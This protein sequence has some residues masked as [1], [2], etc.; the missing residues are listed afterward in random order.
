MN[1]TLHLLI[2]KIERQLSRLAGLILVT[3][4]L[5]MSGY[6]VQAQNCTVNAGIDDSVC[7]TYPLQLHGNSGGVYQG[8]GNIHW[9]QKSGPTVTISNPYALNPYISGYVA[10]SVYWFYI[11]AKCLDGSLVFDSVMVRIKPVTVAD[12]GPDLLSCPGTNVLTLA[13]NVPG[14]DETGQWVVVGTNN[15]V[16]VNSIHAFNSSIT[17]NGCC[18]IQIH[19]FTTYDDMAVVNLGGNPAVSAGTGQTIGGCYSATTSATLDGSYGGCGINGQSGHW[20]FISGPSIP[21]FSNSSSNSSKVTNLVEGTYILRW[22]VSGPCVNGTADVTIHVSAPLGSVTGA[23]AGSAQVF[24]DQRHEFVLTGNNPLYVNET[25]TWTQKSTRTGVT[26]SSIHSPVTNVLITDPTGL[27]SFEWTIV[28]TLTGCRSTSTVGITYNVNPT[29]TASTEPYLACGDSTATITYSVT[30]NGTVQWS[31]VDGPVNS[32]YKVIPTGWTNAGAS[33]LSVPHLTG[34]GTYVIRLRVS[35]GTGNVCETVSTDVSVTTSQPPY[36]PNAG[37]PQLLAC[38]VDTT[39]L[40]GNEILRGTGTWYLIRRPSG[41]PYPTFSDVNNP[42]SSFKN[43]RNGIYRLRWLSSGGPYCPSLQ[44][45][46]RVIV[47]DTIPTPA[48]AGPDSTICDN[49]P[50]KLHLC[51]C[52]SGPVSER[53]NNRDH[54]LRK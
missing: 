38:N 41:S 49:Y 4:L 19:S 44:S 39:F 51:K 31:I 45:E 17:L 25:G 47:A 24:C 37:T 54:S 3:G 10:D 11:S 23:S 21:V 33:P 1:T 13:G 46:T 9:T 34:L 43:L 53:R 36:T 30:G 6:T 32:T 16:T 28:N 50:Y 12:A 27:Y 52:R 20:T 15:G 22:T 7:F 29:I 26:I 40:A 48:N 35:P 5:L 18:I 8:T 14:A 42:N 2:T